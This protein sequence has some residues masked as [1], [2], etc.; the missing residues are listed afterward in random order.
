MNTIKELPTES[1]EY[2]L[3]ISRFNEEPFEKRV[4][5]N[6]E[7]GVWLDI[8]SGSFDK[9]LTSQYEVIGNADKVIHNAEWHSIISFRKPD[10]F[11]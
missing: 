7:E 4:Q 2:I 5:Y 9:P 11:D 8:N 10:K 3:S 6:Y 1:G